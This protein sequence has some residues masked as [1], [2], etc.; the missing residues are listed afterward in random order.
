MNHQDI[1][2]RFE[3]MFLDLERQPKTGL[4]FHQGLQDAADWV[5]GLLQERTEVEYDPEDNYY[6]RGVDL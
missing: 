2:T 3:E 4:E 6:L 5:Y 1:V